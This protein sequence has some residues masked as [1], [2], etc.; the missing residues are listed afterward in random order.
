MRGLAEGT[1]LPPGTDAKPPS[2]LDTLLPFVAGAYV[3]GR[4]DLVKRAAESF[5]VGKAKKPKR[6]AVQNAL[7]ILAGQSEEIWRP[8]AP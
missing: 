4:L 5:P 1:P 2:S 7:A 6:V 3:S 8:P